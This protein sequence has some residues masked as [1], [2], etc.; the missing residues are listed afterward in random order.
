MNDTSLLQREFLK[1]NYWALWLG[2]GLVRLVC[3]LPLRARW[4]IG[5]ALGLMGYRLA[6]KRRHIVKTNLA[7]CFPNLGEDERA[8]LA[9]DNFR[10]SGISIIETAV[11][12]FENP[13]KF[14]DLVDIKGLEHLQAAID[15]GNGVI[16]LGAHLSTLDFCGAIL[17]HHQ[18][19]DVMYRRNKNKLLEAVMT[20]GRQRN[21]ASAI[22]RTDIRQVIR[23]LKR[24]AVVWYG[25]DQDYG[26]KHSIFVPFF[27]QSAATITATARIAQITSAAVVPFSHYRDIQTGRYRIVLGQAL[28]NYPSGDDEMDCIRIN[29]VIERAIEKSPEQYWWVHRRF[30]TTPNGEPRPY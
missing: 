16:L 26:R 1:P 6:R 28:D 17:G 23:R 25:P 27:G 11:A 29:T 12:W 30:K 2:I 5:E 9:V 20:R 15:Q 8:V 3:L 10:S 21:F 14:V 13:A 18:P 19:F 7:L 24:G 4:K 22:E